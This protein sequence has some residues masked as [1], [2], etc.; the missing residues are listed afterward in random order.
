MNLG[1]KGIM[2]KIKTF[3]D[4]LPDSHRFFLILNL[5]FLPLTIGLLLLTHIYIINLICVTVLQKAQSYQGQFKSR[6]T[7]L[8]TS[9]MNKNVNLGGVIGQ[10]GAKVP[11][12]LKLSVLSL[13]SIFS[14]SF[15]PHPLPPLPPLLTCFSYLLAS[16]RFININCLFT[17]SPLW[18]WPSP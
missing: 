16:P 8:Q 6:G 13:L 17:S 10:K 4:L 15:L 3:N 11:S 9:D 12:Q 2:S 14:S 18:K 1:V 5:M 7:T